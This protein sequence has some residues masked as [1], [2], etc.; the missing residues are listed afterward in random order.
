MSIESLASYAG[1]AN[2]GFGRDPQ[3]A[4]NRNR[5]REARGACDDEPEAVRLARG[6]AAREFDHS[7]AVL[8]VREAP[9]L[10]SKLTG[11]KDPLRDFLEATNLKHREPTGKIVFATDHFIVDFYQEADSERY[12]P[13]YNFGTAIVQTNA[14]SGR[15]PRMYQYGGQLLSNDIEGS[16][17]S[18]WQVAWDRWLR[19]T[20]NVTGSNR[21]AL[22]Y[23]IE[24]TYRD[25]VR[26]GY[27]ISMNQGAQSLIPGQAS[28]SF[29]MFVIHEA[30]RS[31]KRPVRLTEQ[32]G[33]NR[34]AS[35]SSP[36]EVTT[37]IIQRPSAGSF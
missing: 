34:L 3:T 9:R 30:S 5:R 4:K 13:V 7:H 10:G 35:E 2:G 33:F 12:T 27:L 16:A 23:F 29:T 25:Q 11:S 31:S 21:Q 14:R 36:T 20:R 26:R 24:L 15:Q 6:H 8:V 17:F 28:F 1:T 37:P 19:V 32:S 22:P 18:A